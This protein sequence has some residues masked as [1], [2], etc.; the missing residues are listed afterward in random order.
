MNRFIYLALLLLNF[1]TFAQSDSQSQELQLK[2]FKSDSALLAQQKILLSLSKENQELVL[3]SKIDEISKSIKA[4]G[5]S[6]PT[7]LSGDISFS[8]GSFTTAE[9]KNLTNNLLDTVIN[10]FK[11][12]L[13]DKSTVIIY[14]ESMFSGINQYRIIVNELDILHKNFISL[15]GKVE[16]DISKASVLGGVA[17]GISAVK[18]VADLSTL[19]KTEIQRQVIS[20][21]IPESYLVSI[22]ARNI[23]SNTKLYYP[24]IV[25]MLPNIDSSTLL[26]HL[27]EIEIMSVD[28][29]GS[30]K[31][32][33][34]T[35]LITVNEEKIALLKKEIDE[36]KL[37]LSK[38]GKDKKQKIESIKSEIES[39]Q[40]AIEEMT[41]RIKVPQKYLKN[42][43]EELKGLLTEFEIIN[44]ALEQT[45]ETN[46]PKKAKEVLLGIEALDNKLK[47]K[48]YI[49]KVKASSIG[50]NIIRKKLWKT[51]LTTSGLVELE[52]LLFNHEGQIVSGNTYSSYNT[53]NLISK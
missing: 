51:T 2:K 48:S 32:Y 46:S 37:E 10:N 8:Q 45:V 25:P 31:K 15:K 5:D 9:I 18:A 44:K 52:Y 4:F 3:N 50:T 11:D 1:S 53:G 26:S 17:L 47:S 24:L 13:K 19:F 29:K 30:M 36:K 43:E 33:D 49:L 42:Y 16:N 6:K 41:N 14:N 38:L 28:I 22:L 21:Q 12:I 34:L 40:K 20:E 39:N 7:A 27:R 35:N 23:D